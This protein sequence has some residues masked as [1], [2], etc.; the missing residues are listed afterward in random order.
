[1][2]TDQE[3]EQIIQ[4]LHKHIGNQEQLED[5]LHN[6]LMRTFEYIQKKP[7]QDIKKFIIKSALNDAK[8]F[9]S[10]GY[11]RYVILA[12]ES[13]EAQLATGETPE[14]KL[15]RKT[16]QKALKK[17]ISTLFPKERHGLNFLYKQHKTKY[18]K[19]KEPR[20]NTYK[21]NARHAILKIRAMIDIKEPRY[22]LTEEDIKVVYENKT[23][24]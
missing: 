4:A 6:A 5:S 8:R 14:K 1:M 21:A 7:I 24:V 12:D 15:L 16:E 20:Y 11:S 23:T 3:Y 13:L 22:Y 19:S 17:A 18:G 9:R 2:L 10:T